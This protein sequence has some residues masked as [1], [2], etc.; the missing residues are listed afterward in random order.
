MAANDQFTPLVM[1]DYAGVLRRVN[2]DL[3]Q[4]ISVL[5]D[6]ARQI[7]GLNPVNVWMAS[8]GVIR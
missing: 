4:D 2:F 5:R 1:V 6:Y 7:L 8:G 3:T